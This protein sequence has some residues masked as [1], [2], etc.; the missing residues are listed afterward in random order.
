MYKICYENICMDNTETSKIEEEIKR[1]DSLTLLHTNTT[2]AFNNES[3]KRLLD[4]YYSSQANFDKIIVTIL[5]A[6]IGY[7]MHII[8]DGNFHLSFLIAI[9]ISAFGIFLSLIRYDVDLKVLKLEKERI[10]LESYSALG[11]D[12]AKGLSNLETLIEK[13]SKTSFGLK[14]WINGFVI[15]SLI[16]ATETI[17]FIKE[18][19]VSWM[20]QIMTMVICLSII[21]MFIY[22]GSNGITSKKNKIYV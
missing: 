18:N 19:K 15:M 20:C 22:G 7:I 11:L 4:V 14:H 2:L 16:T 13:H 6:E 3:Y 1:K 17:Y 8:K 5:F 9:A 12:Y 21:L 10:E